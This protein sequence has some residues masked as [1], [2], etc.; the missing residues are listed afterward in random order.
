MRKILVPLVS[1]DGQ[2]ERIVRFVNQYAAK[3]DGEV[4]FLHCLPASSH[5]TPTGVSAFL[6]KL[7]SIVKNCQSPS[8]KCGIS[9]GRNECLVRS[10]SFS[11]VIPQAM[12]EFGSDLLIMQALEEEPEIPAELQEEISKVLNQVRCP[13]LMVPRQPFFRSFQTIVFAT[14]YTDF[15]PQV[16]EKLQRWADLFGA[17]IHIVQFF[18]RSDRKKLVRLKRAMNRIKN[19]VWHP[20]LAFHLV[21][22]ED[23]LEGMADFGERHE[24]DLLV[25]AT[26]D[27]YLLQHLYSKPYLKTMAYQTTVPLLRFYQQKT[28]PCSG[29]C[30]NCTSKLPAEFQLMLLGNPAVETPKGL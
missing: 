7:R 15:D 28:K 10:G 18:Q 19:G 2:A 20:K 25:L 21:E 24:A 12:E 8:C 29:S 16:L 30:T 26:Q 4:I 6:Q 27:D 11:E 14:D 17:Q 9:S 13:V 5:L 23:M 3:V 22:E 1:L